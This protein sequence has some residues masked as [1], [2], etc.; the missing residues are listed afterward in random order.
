MAKDFSISIV[1]PDRS[2]VE[3]RAQS[4][5]APGI[6]GYFGVMA[7]HVAMVS[8]LRAGIVEYLDTKGQRHHI[9]VSG[10]FAEISG[11]RLTILADSAW[12]AS[13]IDIKQEEQRLEKARRA[14]RGEDTTMTS[15]EAT[16]EIERA[17]ARIRTAQRNS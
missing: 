11:E 10:G 9:A 8:A 3:D 7:G 16:L 4:V 2:V 14:L 5:V 1:A 13:E 17:M 12:R 15:Q 6:E